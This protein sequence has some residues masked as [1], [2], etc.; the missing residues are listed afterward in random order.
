MKRR[1]I[2]TLSVGCIVFVVL[3][4]AFTSLPQ[5]VQAANTATVAVGGVPYAVAITPD[6]KYA[7]VPNI[8]ENVSVI[9]PLQTR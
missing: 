5:P 1:T 8:S 4:C 3:I 9:K 6:G 7:Y 2:R